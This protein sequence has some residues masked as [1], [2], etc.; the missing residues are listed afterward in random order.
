MWALRSHPKRYPVGIQAAYIDWVW[1]AK[2]REK[3]EVCIS[4]PSFQSGTSCQMISYYF[5]LFLEDVE[6][7]H[8]SDI[9]ELTSGTF[10]IWMKQFHPSATAAWYR[11]S[12][13]MRSCKFQ[14]PNR[15][16]TAVG[17]LEQ[18]RE[19]WA[20]L[21]K[22]K[23]LYIY[24]EYFI[25]NKIAHDHR[26]HIIICNCG[27]HW[28]LSQSGGHLSQVNVPMVSKVEKVVEIPQVQY[29]D[30]VVDIPVQKQARNSEF[31]SWR[32][33]G[34]LVLTHLTWLGTGEC[35]YDY[36]S[37]E[38]CWNSSSGAPWIDSWRLAALKQ[39]LLKTQV[40]RFYRDRIREEVFVFQKPSLW[41]WIIY[42][43]FTLGC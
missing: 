17:N 42:D 15:W 27:H 33:P 18:D 25:V 12:L 20:L 37:G 1:A 9:F 43:H 23:Q 36:T 2:D 26:V 14:S 31:W 3:E 10:V 40:F 39:K 24:I 28:S 7:N 8:Q 19:I 11:S 22:Y 13:S 16:T 6:V 29:I 32:C 5:I 21:C 4:S 41:I 35:S 34:P 38:D 30:K